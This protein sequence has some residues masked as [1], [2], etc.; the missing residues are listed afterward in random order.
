MRCVYL[1]HPVSAP[2]REGI[3]A[4]RARAAR[5]AAWI[6]TTYRVAVIADWLWCTGELDETP[7]NRTL[8]LAMD[9]ELVSRADEVW[10]VGER[11]SQGM[12]LEAEEA[13][14][15]GK[16][17]FDLT[18]LDTGPEPPTVRWT[19]SFIMARQWQPENAGRGGAATT[20]DEDEDDT[21]VL[22]GEG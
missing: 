4:N 22:G 21:H 13:F 15:L 17:V 2:T 12:K 7:E 16:M 11:I 5:W 18:A 9:V 19:S 10:M 6:L 20:L 3:E 8:G 14:R 1:A